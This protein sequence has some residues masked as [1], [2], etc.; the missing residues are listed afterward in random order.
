MAV[1]IYT[2]P[3]C[4]FCRAAKR[5][6]QEKRVR[7]R[8]IDVSRAATAADEIARRAGRRAVPVID[9]NGRLI[10]G[11]DKRRLNAALGIRG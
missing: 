3:T 2:N 8:E 7:F 10:V 6:L 5:Y 11:F 9:V 1:T 4:V